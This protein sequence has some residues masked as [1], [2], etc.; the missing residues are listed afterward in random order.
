MKS[1]KRFV[2]IALGLAAL[3]PLGC[4][5]STGPAIGRNNAGTG[6]HTLKVVGDVSATDV[7]GTPNYNTAFEVVLTNNLG[8]PVTGATVTVSNLTAGSIALTESVAGSGDYLASRTVFYDGDFGLTVIRGADTVRDVVV[9]GVSRFSIVPPPARLDTLNNA[10]QPLTVR[11][12]VP[13]QAK[14]AA[15]ETRDFPNTTIGDT[16]IYVIPGASNPAR[17]D[18]RVRVFRDNEVD[19]AGGLAGS[20]FRLSVRASVDPFCVRTPGGVC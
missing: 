1:L 3:G 12:T 2:K 7:P 10:G 6:T 11:W 16:G 14:T 19:V 20:I 5:S 18:Q 9:G 13:S 4:S 17:P 8:S 15:I